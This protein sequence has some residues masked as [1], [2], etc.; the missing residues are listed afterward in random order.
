MKNKETFEC[1]IC[2]NPVQNMGAICGA[3]E[4]ED[5]AENARALSNL[6][7][8]IRTANK[9]AESNG[10]MHGE[11]ELGCIARVMDAKSM[12]SVPPGVDRVICAYYE[13]VTGRKSYY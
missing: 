1:V 9:A 6:K 13:R 5:A 12:V 4:E 7:K 2:D 8:M 10:Y 11:I 3:C